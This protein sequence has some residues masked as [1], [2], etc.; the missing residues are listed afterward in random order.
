MAGSVKNL[1]NYT[2]YK[3]MSNHFRKNVDGCKNWQNDSP[4]VSIEKIFVE[5]FD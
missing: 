1:Q 2:F 4:H 3:Y 5:K